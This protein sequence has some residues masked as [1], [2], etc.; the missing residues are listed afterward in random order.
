LIEEIDVH[1]GIIRKATADD[2]RE[3]RRYERR[4]KKCSGPS[5]YLEGMTAFLRGRIS[6][7]KLAL[8]HFNW[9]KQSIKTM[10]ELA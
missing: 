4:A 10:E 9:V 2:L 6:S 1:V 5:L 7:N 8:Q 3:R